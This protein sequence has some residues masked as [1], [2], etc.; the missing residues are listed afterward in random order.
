MITLK[1]WMDL[2]DCRITEGSEWFSNVPHLYSLT[3]WN[4]DNENG[5]SLNI[6]FDPQD[7]Q[8]VY[9]VEVCDYKNNRAYQLKDEKLESGDSQAWDDV[10]YTDL[11]N[12]EDFIT[13]ARAIIAGEDYDQRVS[14]PIDLPEDVVYTLMK[15]AHELDITF[16]QHMNNIIAAECK[17]VLGEQYDTTM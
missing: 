12:K 13:K 16:N 8:R 17:R 3:S 9:L 5:Y 7:D 10:N 14:V 2:V 4:G 11:E 15:Q 1:E 6:V